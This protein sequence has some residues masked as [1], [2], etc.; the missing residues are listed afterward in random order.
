MSTRPRTSWL[1]IVTWDGL[2]PAAIAAGPAIAENVFP[3]SDAAEI[4]V[5]VLVPIVA[6]LIRSGVGVRQIG[7]ITGD[8]IPRGRQLALAVAI[9]LLLVLE[10]FVAALTFADDEPWSAWLTPIV[11]YVC[12]LVSIAMAL[13]PQA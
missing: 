3:K 8:P 2:L 13:R 5:A 11:L 4:V 6:A 12:Y 1:L 7:R 9:I 10:G